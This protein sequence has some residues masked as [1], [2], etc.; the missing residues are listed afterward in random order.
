[1]LSF[2]FPLT[3]TNPLHDVHDHPAEGDLQRPQVGVHGEDLDNLQVA[4]D[5][6]SAKQTLGDQEWIVSVPVL[7]GNVHSENLELV[8]HFIEGCLSTWEIGLWTWA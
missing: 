2:L 7:P 4:G 1:M 8:W 5:H 6:P 3:Q